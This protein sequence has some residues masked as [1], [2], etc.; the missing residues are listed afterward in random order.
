MRD[1]SRPPV[2]S[3][4][5]DARFDEQHRNWLGVIRDP[6]SHRPNGAYFLPV[7]MEFNRLIWE[8]E[9]MFV[10]RA[11]KCG[12]HVRSQRRLTIHVLAETRRLRFAE[13]RKCHSNVNQFTTG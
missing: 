6:L 12:H 2:P 13:R 1:S 9:T 5:P 8:D 11:Q 4:R 7:L 3:R 10:E